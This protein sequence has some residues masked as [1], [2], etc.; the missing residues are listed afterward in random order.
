MTLLSIKDDFAERTLTHIPGIWGK[1]DYVSALQERQIRALG[2]RAYLWRGGDPTS[3]SG[4]APRA[5]S[6]GIAHAPATVGGGYGVL[7]RMEAGR[8]R[9]VR[10]IAGPELH[11]APSAGRGRGARQSTSI[12]SLR[13]FRCLRPGCDFRDGRRL[14]TVQVHGHPHY[15]TH[16]FRILGMLQHAYVYRGERMGLQD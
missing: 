10:R 11:I 7:G 8:A 15:P 9:G 16:H 12:R 5:V 2:A 13:C 14:P 6:P 1:L 4:S 3:P